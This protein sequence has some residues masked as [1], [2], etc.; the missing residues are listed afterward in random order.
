M[1]LILLNKPCKVLSQFRDDD[2]RTTLARFVNT[3]AVYPAGRLDYDSEG[4]I[5]L[6][7]DGRLQMHISEPKFKLAKGYWAQVEGVATDAALASLVRGV[8]LKD[9]MASALTVVAI[10]APPQ[11]WERVPPVRK[12]KQIPTSWLD[13]AIDEGRNRQIRRMTA[14]VDLPTL[15]LI[16]HR[17]GPWRLDDL[18]PGQSRQIENEEAWQ[19]LRQYAKR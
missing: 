6:T 19:Q 8:P 15:R 16:R 18:L 5:V 11:L 1:P 4:L 14:S 13:V 10:D 9:G 3:P 17:I 12:R 2:G 7:D